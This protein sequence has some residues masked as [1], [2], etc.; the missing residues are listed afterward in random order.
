MRITVFIALIATVVIYACQGVIKPEPPLSVTMT[1]AASKKCVHDTVCAEINLKYPVLSGGNALATQAINDSIMDFVRMMLGGDPS[2]TVPQTFDSAV[3]N[4]YFLLL[5][6]TAVMPDYAQPFTFELESKTLYQTSRLISFEIHNYSYT[7]GAHGNYASGLYTFS[8]DSG[9]LLDLTDVV[10]DTAALRPMLEAGFVAAK[11]NPGETVKL[12]DLVYPEFLSL[13]IPAQWCIVK[14][15]IRFT[16]N[17]YE[18][19]PYAVGQADITLTWE[20]LNNL[21]ERSKWVE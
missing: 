11:S 20:Q 1:E 12:S 7:G 9:K 18:V 21:V 6:Q 17:P 10:K 14:E 5:D 4:L 8:L 3:Y 2:W 15:G 16:Y 19:A 13:P